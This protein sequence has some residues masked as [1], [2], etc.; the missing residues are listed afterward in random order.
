V[1]SVEI[2][3]L[4][5]PDRNTVFRQQLVHRSADC[6]VTLMARTELERPVS[7]AG[8]VVLEPD[9]P[10][11][12]F[13]FPGQWHDIGRFHTSAGRFTGYYANVLTPVQFRSP[14]VWQTT[15]LFLD[16]W[17]G[18]DGAV[19]LLDEEELEAALADGSIDPDRARAA[20]AEATRVVAA[21]T[22]GEWPPDVARTWT[23]ERARAAVGHPT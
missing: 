19:A 10:V 21:A 16:V 8:A 5:L 4:R 23:L 22:R 13:T 12:W 1:S 17:L 15:D 3:Y 14:N 9:A 6:I 7:A 20:R 18:T 11:V 2:H